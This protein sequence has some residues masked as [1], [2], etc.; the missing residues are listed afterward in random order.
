MNALTPKTI[1]EKAIEQFKIVAKYL[2]FV[3]S[4][5]QVKVGDKV[6]EEASTIVQKIGT[7]ENIKTW[8]LTPEQL[9]VWAN[10]DG[11]PFVIL[12]GGNGTGKTMLLK[13]VAK[14][15]AAHQDIKVFYGI[16]WDGPMVGVKPLLYFLIKK[17]LEKHGIKTI[18]IDLSDLELGL[19]SF[20][21]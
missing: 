1:S 12:T 17:E 21:R 4:A 20:K 6:D 15:K 14:L 16:C 9:S 10:S 18:L 8:C 11:M 7:A 19:E 5:A 13:E 2:C 3:A